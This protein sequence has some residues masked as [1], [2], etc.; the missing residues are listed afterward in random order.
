MSCELSGCDPKPLSS[1][2]WEGE[3]VNEVGKDKATGI[4]RVKIN[5]KFYRP[6]EVVSDRD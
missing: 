2:R 5:K 1:S 6:T 4:I 3:G